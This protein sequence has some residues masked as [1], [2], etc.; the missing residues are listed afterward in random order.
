MDIQYYIH[1]LSVYAPIFKNPFFS[2]LHLNLTSIF[3]LCHQ[4]VHMN[5]TCN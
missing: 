5:V 4:F 2:F 1:A 3:R